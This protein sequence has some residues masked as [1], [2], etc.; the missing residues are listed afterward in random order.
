MG[1][2]IEIRAYFKL[3][4]GETIDGKYVDVKILDRTVRYT[5]SDFVY[6]ATYDEY[7]FDCNALYAHQLD[8][9]VYFTMYNAN[10]SACTDTMQ[11]SVGSYVNRQ[12]K[13]NPSGQYTPLITAMMKYGLASKTYGGF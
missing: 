1:G 3:N 12:M 7:Y 5:A 13:N 8:T 6:D 4:D 10:G 11:Y 9:P 2:A